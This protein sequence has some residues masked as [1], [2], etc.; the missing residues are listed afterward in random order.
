MPRNPS[1]AV[2]PDDGR[3]RGWRPG[4]V[5]GVVAL[6]LAFAAAVRLV[7]GPGP[8]TPAFGPLLFLSMVASLGGVGA[9]VVTRRPH[10]PVGWLLWVCATLVTLAISGADYVRL[11][12]TGVEGALPLTVAIAWLQGLVMLP[13]IMLIV[14]VMP[15]YFPDGQ[16]RSRRWRWVVLMAAVA[17]AAVAVP[18]AASPGPLVN[19]SI[20]NPVGVPALGDLSWLLTLSNAISLAILPLAIVSC[21]LKYRQGTPTARQQLKWFGAAAGFTVASFGAAI[22]APISPVSGVGWLLGLIGLV[23]LPVAIG[24]AILRY[25]LYEIDRLISRTVGWAIVTGILVAVFAG[26]VVGL[27]T[28]LAGLTQGQTLAVAA[29]TLLAFALFQPVRRRVQAAVD[30]RFNRARYDGR[31]LIDAFAAGLRQQA[32]LAE[33]NDGVLAVV[34]RSVD[35]TNTAMWIRPPREGTR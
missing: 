26:A 35:P 20:E 15:L 21:V 33:I 17:I 30:R 8:D 16:L 27:Q 2:G 22:V 9:L 28:M 5:W 7:A 11:S 12:V 23:L 34:T 14:G 29:S 24:I 4:I 1:S 19:T 13:A 10:D 18:S 25:R 31:R 6:D 3:L 32:N